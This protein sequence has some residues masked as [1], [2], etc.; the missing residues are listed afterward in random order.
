MKE[1]KA[2]KHEKRISKKRKLWGKKEKKLVVLPIGRSG[3][4]ESMY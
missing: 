2:K 3:W 1:K 4:A